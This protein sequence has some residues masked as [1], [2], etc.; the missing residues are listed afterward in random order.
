LRGGQRVVF[1]R[2]SVEALTRADLDRVKDKQRN[3]ALVAALRAWIDAGKSADRPPGLGGAEPIRKVRLAMNERVGVEIDTGNR[4]RPASAARGGL[5]RLD[6]FRR[7]S[8]SGLERYYFTPVYRH[9]VA[10]AALPPMR[11]AKGCVDESRWIAINAGFE[12]LF[13]LYPMNLVEMTKQNGET[14]LGYFRNFDRH[15][16]ALAVSEVANSSSIRRG[17]GARNLLSF[18]K[19]QVDRLGSVHAVEREPRLWRGERCVAASLGELRDSRPTPRR[20]DLAGERPL[21]LRSPRAE[22]KALA[23][24]AA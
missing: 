10:T 5:V 22:E 18:R 2:K 23:L 7:S 20:R 16:G 4:A 3:Q 17:I 1:E 11:V 6:V 15:T 12:F 21:H 9:E 19:L 13:S 14:I 24:D 8:A